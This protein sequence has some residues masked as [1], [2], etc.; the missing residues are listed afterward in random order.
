MPVH[1]LK[2][3]KLQCPFC[4]TISTRG[5][6]LSSHVRGL[7]PKEYGK[8][9]KNPTRLL[10]ATLAVSPQAEPR[11]NQ[12]LHK[13]KAT[14]KVGLAEAVAASGDS[15]QNCLTPSG[16]LVR[17]SKAMLLTRMLTTGALL[18]YIHL[19]GESCRLN[20]SALAFPCSNG[21]FE[22]K[23]TNKWTKN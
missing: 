12:H 21:A 20:V 1:K 18:I 6:G 14:A 13:V 2:P 11:T 17:P 4:S 5:T 16:S 15:I 8:W 7:H 23:G 19:G 9:N 22:K 10:E 3:Q